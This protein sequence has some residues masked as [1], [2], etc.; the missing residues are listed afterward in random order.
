MTKLRTKHSPAAT[1]EDRR[2]GARES[3]T[4]LWL[5]PDQW[6][7]MCTLLT[8]VHDGTLPP[9]RVRDLMGLTMAQAAEKVAS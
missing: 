9:L 5:S 2:C 4:C 1:L 3:K 8:A 7:E 6:A